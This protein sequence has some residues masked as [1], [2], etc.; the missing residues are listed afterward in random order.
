MKKIILTFCVMIMSVINSAYADVLLGNDNRCIVNTDNENQYYFY[1]CGKGNNNLDQCKLRKVFGRDYDVPDYVTSERVVEVKLKKY[2][3]CCGG[4]EWNTG[5]FISVNN[6]TGVISEEEKTVILPE[7]GTCTYTIT[8][9]ACGTVTDVP[10]TDPDTCRNGKKL[11]DNQCVSDCGDGY[12]EYDGICYYGQCPDEE[13][14]L[15]GKKCVKNCVNPPEGASYEIK[16][17]KCVVIC[18][19]GYEEDSTGQCVKVCSG[20][21]PY[22]QKGKCVKNCASGYYQQGKKCVTQCSDGYF[23]MQNACVT[24]CDSGY[25]VK[26]GK[27]I[28]DCE[29]GFVEYDGE[30]VRDCDDGYTLIG[31]E[32]VLDSELDP[33]D[34]GGYGGGCPITKY[35]GLGVNNEC[36]RCNRDSEFFDKKKLTCVKRSDMVNADKDVMK[37]CWRCKNDKL[38]KQCIITFQTGKPVYSALVRDCY[39]AEKADTSVAS[40]SN[41]D[42]SVASMSNIVK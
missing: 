15:L 17:D 26:D 33:D 29:D 11:K 14:F 41:A 27:C 1:F 30:C 2:Y 42:T 25:T 8:T 21:T 34:R 9:N 23:K 10:C 16:D 24:E 37:R 6:E 3:M 32:C 4:D 18:N 7:D 28:L 38:F 36:V 13:L 40:M 31:T 20:D 19:D 22:D 5:S 39:L 12:V 35:Q